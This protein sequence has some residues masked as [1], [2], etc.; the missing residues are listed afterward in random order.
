M[1]SKDDHCY[2]ILLAAILG[3]KKQ[4]YKQLFQERAVQMWQLLHKKI[5][6]KWNQ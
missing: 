1:E 5:K 6:H 3:K 2:S 4:N